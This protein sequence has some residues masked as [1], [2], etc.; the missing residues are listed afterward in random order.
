MNS[1]DSVKKLCFNNFAEYQGKTVLI[2]SGTHCIIP[3]ITVH[4]REDY[5][6]EPLKF[7]PNRFLP[8]EY[9]NRHAYS[10]IPFSAGT[11]NC[12][13]LKFAMIEMKIIAAYIL[14]YFEIFTTDKFE[15]MVLLPN[16]TLTPSKDFT[17]SFKRRRIFNI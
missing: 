8:E 11:R 13:G 7:E 5:F 10:F 16:T 9:T 14:R 6:P 1:L 12:L 2:P 3:P 17:F 4:R 15:D